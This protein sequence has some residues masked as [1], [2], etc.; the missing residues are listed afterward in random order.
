[1]FP[2][3]SR[4][5]LPI[6]TLA[7]MNIEMGK[8]SRK[9]A[10]A[11]S[12]DVYFCSQSGLKLKSARSTRAN[13]G[14]NG[15]SSAAGNW[16]GRRRQ[17]DLDVSAPGGRASDKIW[18]RRIHY[19]DYGRMQTAFLPIKDERGANGLRRPPDKGL[20]CRRRVS[21]TLLLREREWGFAWGS[22]SHDKAIWSFSLT[23]F[24]EAERGAALARPPW[25]RAIAQ[26][27]LLLAKKW[28]YTYTHTRRVSIF[29]IRA[30]T[31]ADHCCGRKFAPRVFNFQPRSAQLHMRARYAGL[32][33]G[34]QL[35]LRLVVRV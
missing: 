6:S 33:F 27:T 29:I 32:W 30:R 31:P 19:P 7:I 28:N 34:H 15:S 9:K 25:Q 8:L 1:M 20:C 18:R 10:F 21:R 23:L 35:L 16:C 22:L 3:V 26:D 13:G 12:S 11:V 5:C 2:M 4:Q 17:S 14:I 24:G